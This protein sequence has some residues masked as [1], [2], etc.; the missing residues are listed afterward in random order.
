[1]SVKE[2]MARIAVNK[3]A[4]EAEKQSCTICKNDSLYYNQCVN[5]NTTA[6]QIEGFFKNFMTQLT[7]S[8]FN[9]LNISSTVFD[10]ITDFNITAVAEGLSR[11]NGIEVANNF[12]T[13]VVEFSDLELSNTELQLKNTALKESHDNLMPLVHGFAR[14][15]CCSTGNGTT[16]ECHAKDSSHDTECIGLKDLAGLPALDHCAT[17]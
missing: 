9:I 10:N 15:F 2:A 13:K 11:L 4:R 14:A 6:N 12:I 1:M 17:V 7:P 5:L 16:F 8:T 3:A